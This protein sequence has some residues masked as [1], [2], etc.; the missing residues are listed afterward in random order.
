MDISDKTLD[1]TYC[2][3]ITDHFLAKNM[4]LPKQFFFKKFLILTAIKSITCCVAKWTKIF[5]ILQKLP[6][7]TVK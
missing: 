6:Y 5:V 1:R 2:F 7:L 4:T 3:K